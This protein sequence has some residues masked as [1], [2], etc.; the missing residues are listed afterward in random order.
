M[1]ITPRASAS[2]RRSSISPTAP[3][4]RIIP[5]RRR[6]KGNAAS[7]TLAS[8]VAAPAAMKPLA[9]HSSMV[10]VVTSSAPRTSTR[11]QRPRR[12]QSWARA[13]ARVVLAQAEFTWVFGP[14][15]PMNWA[16]WEWPIDRTWKR[17]RRS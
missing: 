17:K 3:I 1:G 6:S 7:A 4:P 16:N 2:S 10:S 14:R 12:I 11:S 13:T 8:V 15:A 9:I 5:W